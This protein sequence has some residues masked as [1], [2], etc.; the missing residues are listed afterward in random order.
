MNK[1]TKA[2]LKAGGSTALI[3]GAIL[4]NIGNPVAW[5][6]LAAATFSVG[7]AAYLNTKHPPKL[8]SHNRDQDRVI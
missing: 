5:A 7:K 3:G 4:I 2:A 8:T 6:A 1:E